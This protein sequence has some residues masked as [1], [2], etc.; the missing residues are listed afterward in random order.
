MKEVTLKSFSKDN[1][2]IIIIILTISVFLITFISTYEKDD[3]SSIIKESRNLITSVMTQEKISGLAIAIIDENEIIWAEGFGYTDFSKERPV[4][5]ETI[6]SIQSMSKTITAT[7]EMIAVQDG[8]IDLDKPI[9]T[10]LPSFTVNSRFDEKPQ[11]KITIR[12]LLSCTAGFTQEAPVGNNI[13]PETPSFEAHIASISDTWLRYPVG[14]RYCYSNLG[15]D[16]AGYILQF[17]SG[18]PFPDYVKEKLLGPIQ[19]KTS[20]FDIGVIKKNQN[21][22]IGHSTN[23]SNVP[24]EVPMI[25]SGGFYSNVLDLS[26]FA[27]FHLNRGKINGKSIIRTELLD[28]MYTIPYPVN[29]QYEG[30][31]LGIVKV[32]NDKFN[33]FYYN[34]SGGGFGFLANIVWYPDYGTGLIILTNSDNNTT[35]SQLTNQIMDSLLK[36]K[37]PKNNSTVNVGNIK[38]VSTSINL[39]DLEKYAGRYLGRSGQLIVTDDTPITFIFN[40]NDSYR[41]KFIYPDVYQLGKNY[42]QFMPADKTPAYIVRIND[43]INWDYNDGPND[44]PGPAKQEWENYTGTYMAQLWGQIPVKGSIVLINGYLYYID[45]NGLQSKLIEYEPGLFFISTGE[46]LDFRGATPM[47]SNIHVQKVN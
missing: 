7:T 30:Y 35:Q 17:K 39:S 3:Y 26:R 23:I 14:Q 42:Y 8:L 1:K 15:I 24:L 41:G 6:F 22:A 5:P 2:I 44:Q 27:Q 11:E 36:L 46:C 4:T 10:Y 38:D 19:M 12:N 40:N 31:A 16:L 34:H 9:S 20:T 33:T 18:K 45:P 21:R 25:P 29:G 43:G 47:F 28:E 37:Q 13:Y 32:W